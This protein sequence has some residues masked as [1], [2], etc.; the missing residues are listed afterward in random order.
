MRK[1][2]CIPRNF[3]SPRELQKVFGYSPFLG[4]FQLDARGPILLRSAVVLIRPVLHDLGAKHSGGD[5][6]ALGQGEDYN[7]GSKVDHGEGRVVN[8]PN[9][10]DPGARHADQ[11]RKVVGEGCDRCGVFENDEVVHPL[12]LHRIKDLDCIASKSIEGD[13]E[14]SGAHALP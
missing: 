13:C 11:M 5:I 4:P 1:L 3:C 12:Q 6:K 7:V 10:N 2:Y 8:A 9:Y 14:V